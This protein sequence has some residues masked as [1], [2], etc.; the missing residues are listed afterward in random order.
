MGTSIVGPGA[1]AALGGARPGI[2]S[3]ARKTGGFFDEAGQDGPATEGHKNPATE[4]TAGLEWCRSSQRHSFPP[5]R[6]EGR[7]AQS[8]EYFFALPRALS[9]GYFSAFF[10]IL[11]RAASSRSTS[12]LSASRT[13]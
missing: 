9:A 7:P 5:L 12:S 2:E 6:R 10:A 13:R 11:S 8:S 3:L 4:P 1:D